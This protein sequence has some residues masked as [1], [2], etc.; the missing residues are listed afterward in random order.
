LLIAMDLFVRMTPRGVRFALLVQKQIV[1]S[2]IYFCLVLR[3]T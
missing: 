2:K 1:R 3:R